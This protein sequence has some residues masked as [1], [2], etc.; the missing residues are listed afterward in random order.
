MGQISAPTGLKIAT[1]L[2]AAWMLLSA[3]GALILLALWMLWPTLPMQAEIASLRARA[4]SLALIPL[5]SNTI[6]D[7]NG[8]TN[9]H[10][11]A[12]SGGQNDHAYAQ[13]NGLS[14]LAQRD[15]VW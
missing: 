10:A 11:F 12:N 4:Q 2:P 8:N 15:F 14:N 7:G 1:S 13:R 5:D 6:G 9:Q 3:I